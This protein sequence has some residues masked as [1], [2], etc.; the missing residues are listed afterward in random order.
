MPRWLCDESP[1]RHKVR[2]TIPLL[3]QS[4]DVLTPKGSETDW[5]T[6]L[7]L[8][9][10]HHLGTCFEKCFTTAAGLS[11][12]GAISCESLL[13][14]VW[15]L[16][17]WGATAC[18]EVC[19]LTVCVLMQ[20]NIGQRAE[21]SGSNH[22]MLCKS[23]ACLALKVDSWQSLTHALPQS[24]MHQAGKIRVCT[25]PVVMVA[26]MCIKSNSVRLWQWMTKCKRK[27]VACNY[28]RNIS[29]NLSRS[30]KHKNCKFDTE[31]LQ[32]RLCNFCDSIYWI[33]L[34]LML[35]LLI[36]TKEERRERERLRENREMVLFWCLQLKR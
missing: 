20:G 13:K 21:C 35:R 26:D 16:E 12:G 36:W 14:H 28:I 10:D 19:H 8:W 3:M 18:N 34:P 2:P 1:A 24:L 32:C 27:L 29:W 33:W 5:L 30:N 15:A 11:A 4:G 17:R 9:R 25:M 31:D 6:L 22:Q 7:R 23:R